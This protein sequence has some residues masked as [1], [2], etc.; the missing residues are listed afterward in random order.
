MNTK[1]DLTIILDKSSSMTH[2][3]DDAIGGFNEFLSQYQNQQSIQK[4][5][6]N[7][8]LVQFNGKVFSIFTKE[9]IQEV[10]PINRKT[11]SPYGMTALY[12]AV[13]ITIKKNKKRLKKDCDTEVVILIITDGLDNV[14]SRFTCSEVSKMIE[15]TKANR[16]WNYVFIGSDHNAIKEASKLSIPET[17]SLQ[18]NFQR[19]RGFR[20]AF[21]SFDE[22]FTRSVMHKNPK[23]RKKFAFSQKDRLN[24]K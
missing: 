5:S 7:L 8:S 14:S 15:K 9:P 13:G 2:I 17:N 18:A 23:H 21:R 19:K 16:N 3:V 22:S 4:A 20:K 1:V 24:N 6:I 11:Y 10:S 12:D